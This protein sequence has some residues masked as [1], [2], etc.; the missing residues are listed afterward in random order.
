MPQCLYLVSEKGYIHES[1]EESHHP[2]HFDIPD[3]EGESHLLKMAFWECI[4]ELCF[5]N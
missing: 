2:F 1:R 5:R 3:K 4:V